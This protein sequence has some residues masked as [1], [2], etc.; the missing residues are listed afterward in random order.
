MV[1][2]VQRA[3]VSQL[4]PAPQV[5]P[6][7]GKTG[8]W[9]APGITGAFGGDVLNQGGKACCVGVTLVGEAGTETLRVCN[10]LTL[11]KWVRNDLTIPPTLLLE[12]F[13]FIKGRSW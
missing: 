13:C 2:F 4:S 1:N 12:R 10:D 8:G 5:D 7:L 6:T 9:V 3:V 11:H